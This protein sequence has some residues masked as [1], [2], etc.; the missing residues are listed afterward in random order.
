MLS[1]FLESLF[2]DGAVVFRGPPSDEKDSAERVLARPFADYRLE[3]AGPL[4]ELDLP[5]A[6][7]APEFDHAG[8]EMLY[9]E[10]YMK[11]PRENWLPEG[12]I[13][14]YVELIG[15]RMAS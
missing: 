10:R 6:C 9:A 14:E 4:I 8:L 1:E 11:H 13:A 12:R 7:A 15:K 3:V 2:D 5:T